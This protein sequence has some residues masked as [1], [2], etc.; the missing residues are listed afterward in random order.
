MPSNGK[1]DVDFERDVPT[2]AADIAALERARQ[3]KSLSTEAYLE[4]LSRMP[5][6]AVRPWSLNTPDDE[7]FEL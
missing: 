5:K 3:L 6:I 2:T 4:W 1:P 7:T